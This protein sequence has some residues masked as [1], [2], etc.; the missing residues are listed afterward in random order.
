MDY[1]VEQLNLN[2]R[3]GNLT[4]LQKIPYLNIDRLLIEKEY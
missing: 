2:I 4:N 1:E 3:V